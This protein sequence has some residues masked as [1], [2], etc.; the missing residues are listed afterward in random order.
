MRN[1][2]IRTHPP[3]K[4]NGKRTSGAAQNNCISMLKKKVWSRHCK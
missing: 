2:K 1:T 3:K 4:Y